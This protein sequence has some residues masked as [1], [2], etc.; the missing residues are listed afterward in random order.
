MAEKLG[1]GEVLVEDVQ[2]MQEMASKGQMNGE[3]PL[4]LSQNSSLEDECDMLDDDELGNHE[5]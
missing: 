5:N 4:D 2:R 1:E 3:T